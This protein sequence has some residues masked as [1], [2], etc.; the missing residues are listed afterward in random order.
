[1]L[2]FFKFVLLWLTCCTALVAKASEV[3]RSGANVGLASGTV[4]STPGT[5]AAASENMKIRFAFS[6]GVGIG[7]AEFGERNTLKPVPDATLHGSTPITGSYRS[8]SLVSLRTIES[9][10]LPQSPTRDLVLGAGVDV[11]TRVQ[12]QHSYSAVK[13]IPIDIEAYSLAFEAGVRK[14][15][16]GLQSLEI[17]GGLD[18]ILNGKTSF[19]YKAKDD[20]LAFKEYVQE[21]KLGMSSVRMALRGR[22]L[23]QVLD[24]LS[25][26]VEVDGALSR[27]S[28]AARQ[29]A[30]WTQTSSVRAMLAI[31]I[32]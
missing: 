21:D 19:T 28:V 25:A 23:I 5:S 13:G 14:R 12:S 27:F 30:V 7:N 8:S 11:Q 22:Y 2:A 15:V 10:L 9:V 16:W 1:M 24:F 26:G 3:P 17:L 31:D 4:A 18:W 29:D 32:D 6:G 20:S